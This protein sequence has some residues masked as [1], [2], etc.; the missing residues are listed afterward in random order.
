MKIDFKEKVVIVTGGTKNLGRALVEEL[1]KN[2]A[3][4]VVTYLQDDLSAEQMRSSLK[5]YS[6]QLSIYK[7]DCSIKKETEELSIKINNKY[8]KIDV[9]I[10]NAALMDV[11]SFDEINDSRFDLMMR[12]TLRSTIYMSLAVMS[13]MKKGRIVNISSEGVSTGNP[14]ELLYIAAKGGVD[15]VTRVFARYGGPKGITV[16]AVAPHVISSGMGNETIERDPSI[17]SR[18]PIGR[19]GKIEEF[20]SLVMF[21]SSLESEYINGQVIHLNG[22]RIMHP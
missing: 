14:V 13:F 19:T 17:I 6:E 22:G 20:V 16:N 3:Y 7:V 12:H 21:L 1:L 15:A 2:G 5:M 10:N 11:P 8:G 9:L 18:I 4:V